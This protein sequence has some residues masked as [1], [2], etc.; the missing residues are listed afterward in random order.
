MNTIRKTFYDH[1]LFIEEKCPGA[2][3]L[4]IVVRG[5]HAYGTN[6]ETSDI[7]YTGIYIQSQSDIYGTKYISQIND[8][9]SDIVFYEIRRFLE[10]LAV[11]NPTILELLNT[12]EDC[13]I[14]KDPAFDAILSY[15]ELFI[16]KACAK[17]FGG[18]AMQQIHKAK[19]L[20]KKQNW[21]SDKIERKDILDFIYVLENGK[22]IPWK[23]W[24]TEFDEKF[25]GLTN[26]PNA[27]D[28]YGVY[29][30]TIAACCFSSSISEK[31]RTSVKECRIEEG[32]PLGFGYKGLVNT[33]ET[34][35]ESNQLR[36]SSIPKGEIPI[37][38]IIY[39]KDAYTIHCRE[40]KQYT[41][42]LTKRNTQRYVEVKSHNQSIDGKNM[43]HC[44][45]LLDMAKEIG[46]GH[47][48]IVRRPNAEYLLSIRRGEVDLN[49]LIKLAETKIKEIDLIFEN[50][51][52][53]DTVDPELI[54]K[55]LIGIRMM[56]Y[57]N[58]NK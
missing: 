42:W 16:S 31:I 22:S 14:Y 50:S 40:F 44:Q 34:S 36:L 47:G 53:P 5:S 30:D 41:E 19:G 55:I 49:N 38:T 12:P 58:K 24:N 20:N 18:Y 9:K 2:E 54:N 11:N 15:K 33:D 46:E 32:L 29:Y 25:I 17:S 13:I 23:E 28:V 10:L 27:R 4:L 43:M 48:I 6:I 35:G 3:P 45:R 39:N 26:I 37:C 51:D 8:D 57:N 52:L 56:V 7:D 21:E 1:K